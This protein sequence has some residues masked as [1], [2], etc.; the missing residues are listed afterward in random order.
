[1]L[2]FTATSLG[3]WWEADPKEKVQADFDVVAAN[4]IDKKIIP[5]ECKWKNSINDVGE[6]RKLMSKEHLLSEYK[7]RYYYLF[8]KVPFTK[9]AK[10]LENGRVVLITADMLFE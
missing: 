10:K 7:D 2:P 5:G 8:S 9:D 1:M 3:S 4:R 6:I